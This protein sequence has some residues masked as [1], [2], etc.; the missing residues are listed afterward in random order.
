MLILL[1]QTFDAL[2]TETFLFVAVTSNSHVARFLTV[3]DP[4]L[5]E[6]VFDHCHHTC[7]VDFEVFVVEN[8]LAVFT[9]F[10]GT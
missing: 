3:C 9:S 1:G 8:G 10:P 7:C 6:T 4:R 5:E 2:K